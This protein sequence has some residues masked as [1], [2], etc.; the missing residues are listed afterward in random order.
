[1]NQQTENKIK[2]VLQ[3]QAFV[4]PNSDKR[5]LRS[6]LQETS[7]FMQLRNWEQGNP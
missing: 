3:D 1:M 5:V 7:L 4:H 6:S 2:S